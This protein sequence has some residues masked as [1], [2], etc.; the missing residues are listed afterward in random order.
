MK[1]QEIIYRQY[2]RWSY[3]LLLIALIFAILI[4]VILD[5]AI[6]PLSL[7]LQR[8]LVV[9]TLILPSAL[10]A[11]LGFLAL[12]QRDTRWLLALVSVI[13]N[14]LFALFY[15]ALLAIAG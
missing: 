3:G 2:L 4:G 1:G 7:T 15:L 11:V 10:G 12:R 14:G 5:A 8:C 9:A 6:A 13:L